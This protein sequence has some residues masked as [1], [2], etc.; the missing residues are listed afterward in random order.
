M[1][2]DYATLAE[3]QAGFVD[4]D[5]MRTT[6]DTAITGVLESMATRASRLI[7]R[8][9]GRWPG[10]FY[11]TTDDETRYYDGSNGA[12]Q[13]ID[14][15]ISMTSV[16]VAEDGGIASTSYTAWTEDTDF[17]VS[18][19]NWEQ[20]KE[21]FDELV[22]D[23][24]AS[25]PGWYGYRKAVQ[26]IGLFGW[27]ASLPDDVNEACIIQTVRWFT[28]SRQNYQDASANPEVGRIYMTKLD[29]DVAEILWSY[30]VR[31]GNA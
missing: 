17:Y 29:V 7:D 13:P 21:P 27:S 15:C 1:A 6:T 16:S 18:P 10:Y 22:I 9:V 31:N 14:D 20:I 19:Y 25:K 26:V 24:N 8:E 11:P 30:K 3:V 28:R 4:S 2:N 5:T 23:W 12:V